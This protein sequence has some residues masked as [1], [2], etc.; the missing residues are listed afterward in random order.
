VKSDG[1][2]GQIDRMWQYL[3]Q[4]YADP[5]LVEHYKFSLC[6]ADKKFADNTAQM[7]RFRTDPDTRAAI[8]ASISFANKSPSLKILV[9]SVFDD[10]QNT[11]MD[12]NTSPDP[13]ELVDSDRPSKHQNRLG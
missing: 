9:Q 8:N 1:N 5:R 10:T 13:N 6:R 2:K 7:Q 11:T 3:K 12:F 4:E